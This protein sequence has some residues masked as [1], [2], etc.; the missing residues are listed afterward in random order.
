MLDELVKNL[1][2]IKQD[3]AKNYVGHAHIQEVIPTIPS[4][5]FQL[6]ENHLKLLHG[7]AE[8]N[9]IYSNSFE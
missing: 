7:F 3:F 5:Q 9:P 8:K 2:M 1:V 6:D 4:K